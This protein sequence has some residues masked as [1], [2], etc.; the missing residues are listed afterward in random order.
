MKIR[1]LII[2]LF[3][4]SWFYSEPNE[5]V[6]YAGFPLLIPLIAAGVSLIGGG[7]KAGGSLK[8]YNEKIRRDAIATS[9][10][11]FSIAGTMAGVGAGVEQE[12]Q[13]TKWNEENKKATRLRM[14]GGILTGVG[15]ALGSLGS[16]GVGGG[17]NTTP[18]TTTTTA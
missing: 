18:T 9:W 14:A 15:A 16:A 17:G 13:T 2:L 3:A 5:E 1:I 10:G 7:L 8:P 6:S 12:I 4:I 11:D